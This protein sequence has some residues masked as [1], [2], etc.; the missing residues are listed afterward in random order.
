[1]GKKCSYNNAIDESSVFG[2][3][4]H[5]VLS[6]SG[7][8][9]VSLCHVK[10][11]DLGL[12]ADNLVA[13]IMDDSWMLEL[14]KGARRSYELTVKETSAI[15]VGIFKAASVSTSIAADFGELMVSIGASKG[16]RKIFDHAE[17]P[18]AELWKPQ[19]KQ[20][21]GFDFHTICP[22]EKIHFGEAK[23]SSSANPH[24]KAIAQAKRFLEHDKHYRDRVHL[25]S[26]CSDESISHLD[27][28]RFGV[29]VAFSINTEDPLVVLGNALESVV[30][31][32]LTGKVDSVCLVGVSHES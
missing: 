12:M 5:E 17:V 11:S 16:L 1:M 10:V 14:D 6:D 7:V 15:L 4:F 23:Y 2:C 19:I 29:I 8:A 31:H 3:S 28:E 22:Q 9:N 30:S 26:L 20:N 13:V 21:E 27:D 25:I 24:G 32:G 18:I